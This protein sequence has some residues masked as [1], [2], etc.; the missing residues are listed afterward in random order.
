MT[1]SIDDN[2]QL[3]LPLVVTVIEAGPL[4]KQV[5]LL[6]ESL[7]RWGGRLANSRVLVVQP[8]NGPRLQSKTVKTFDKLGIEYNRIVRDDGLDWFAYLNKT[9]AVK[10]VAE[11]HPHSRIVWLDADILIVGEPS[12]LVLRDGVQFAACASDKNIGTARDDD[13]NAPYFRACCSALGVDYASLPYVETEVE[14]IAIRA[15]WNSGVYTFKAASGLAQAHHQFT[16]KLVTNRVA[17]MQSK[18]FFSDQIALGLAAHAL[19]LKFKGLPGTHNYSV[20]P[21]TVSASLTRPTDVRILHYH[22][23]LWPGAFDD[24]CSGL[25]TVNP[26]AAAWLRTQGPLDVAMPIK[27]RIYRKM[28]ELHRKRKYAR[29]L[30][31]ADYF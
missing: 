7:R 4:E 18:L 27:A 11:Q 22:G 16:L 29:T 2:D 31:T 3:E 21:A 19:D 23:C 8:R 5:L 9:A 20:Q 14:R 15:Y 17:S 1:P 30:A 26:D 25:D 24:L 28:L 13:E 10:Y 6:V 12:A